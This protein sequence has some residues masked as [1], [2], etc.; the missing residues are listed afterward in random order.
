MIKDRVDAQ[1]DALSVPAD[2]Q[3]VL[4]AIREKHGEMLASVDAELAGRG[5]E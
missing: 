5:A 2:P 1:A 4:D 3:Q